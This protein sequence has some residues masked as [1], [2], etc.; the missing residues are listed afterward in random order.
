LIADTSDEHEVDFQV[1]YYQE[2]LA[3]IRAQL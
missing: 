1:K 3:Y 2:V